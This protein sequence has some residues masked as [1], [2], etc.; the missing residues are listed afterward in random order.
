MFRYF[1][2]VCVALFLAQGV[3]IPLLLILSGRLWWKQG[4]RLDGLKSELKD[5]RPKGAKPPDI[6]ELI[7]SLPALKPLNCANCG[8]SVVLRETET[9]CPYCETRAPAPEDYAAA[10]A[11]KSEV[12][13]IYASAV[14][15]WRAANALTFRPARLFFLLMIFAEPL[16]I[17]PAVLVGG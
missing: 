13:K 15:N 17:F 9:F 11:L 2:Q 5:S 14:R 10:G 6:P 7:K 12:K 3:S 1:Y 4:K 16:V 8:G